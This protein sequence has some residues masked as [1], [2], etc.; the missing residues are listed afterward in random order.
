MD[1]FEFE[2]RWLAYEGL[3]KRFNLPYTEEDILNL[4]KISDKGK[5]DK[6]HLQ[7][8]VLTNLDKLQ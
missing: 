7:R 3:F 4:V 6:K 1:I 8:L 5:L 2:L